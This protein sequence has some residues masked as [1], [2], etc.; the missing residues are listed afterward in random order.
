MSA[1]EADELQQEEEQ[2]DDVQIEVE[3]SKDV[4]LGRDLILSVFST[5]D[6]LS[7]KHQVLRRDGQKMRCFSTDVRI[8]NENWSAR[9]AQAL[10][11]IS[12]RWDSADKQAT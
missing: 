11:P 5:Q 1:A 3:R 10:F 6:H 9:N 12:E 2:G 7:V 8:E 4:L